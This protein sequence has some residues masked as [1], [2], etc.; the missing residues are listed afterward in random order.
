MDTKPLKNRFS[1]ASRLKELQQIE[2]QKSYLRHHKPSELDK[3]KDLILYLH[4]EGLSATSILKELRRRVR[5]FPIKSTSTI[6]R[7]IS[8]WLGS[9]K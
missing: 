4:K 2:R 1:C 7:R 5:R 8:K 6:T 9:Q 3:Y